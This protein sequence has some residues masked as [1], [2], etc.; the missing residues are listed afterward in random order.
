MYVNRPTNWFNCQSY[1]FISYNHIRIFKTYHFCIW[2]NW[3]KSSIPSTIIMSAF[4]PSRYFRYF[5]SNNHVQITNIIPSHVKIEL[6]AGMYFW[7][8]LNE[9]I[10]FFFNLI[11]Q[12]WYL[13]NII[14]QHWRLSTS[15][16]VNSITKQMTYMCFEIKGARCIINSFITAL[17]V[18]PRL[19]SG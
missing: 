7:N 11:V 17:H 14:L 18:P 6:E 12:G 19:L 9:H 3:H 10:N 16:F 2:G 13:A 1:V 4:W 15:A 8:K 5:I